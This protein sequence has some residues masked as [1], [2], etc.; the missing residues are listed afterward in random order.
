MEAIT[1]ARTMS[2]N[3]FAALVTRLD[4]VGA[5]CRLL[6]EAHPVYDERGTAATVRMRG[7]V[8]I[9]LARLGLP[10]AGLPY[11]LEELDTGH[12]AYLVAAAARAL[13]SCHP[14]A[15]YAQYV[16][17]AI[18]NVR[19]HDDLVS[20][21][22]YGAYVTDTQGSTAVSE[23]LATLRWMG[24]AGHDVAEE[25]ALLIDERRRG[26]LSDA[27]RADVVTTLA[28]IR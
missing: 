20:F 13:R 21:E 1:F 8:L 14:D 3:D 16:V 9:A 23:L 7:W 10:Q 4:D 27:L 5:L 12:D 28:A 6:E 22:S 19:P 17:R 25:L 18:T 15:R 24:F 11:V 26:E 2:E